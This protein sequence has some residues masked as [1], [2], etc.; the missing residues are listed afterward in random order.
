MDQEKFPLALYN[1]L[2]T[3]YSTTPSNQNYPPIG[4]SA[5]KTVNESSVPRG[6]NLIGSHL[7]FKVKEGHSRQ[8]KM[9]ARLV[10]HVNRDCDRFSVRFDSAPTDL[11]ILRIIIALASILGFAIATA[12]FKGAYMQSGPIQRELYVISPDRIRQRQNPIW[13][14]K[15]LPYGIVEAG[16]Q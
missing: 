7:I 12:K 5:Y 1:L 16:L 10:L 8:L 13:K 4:K 15:R 3:G 6:I 2:L 9:K 11:S 14:L